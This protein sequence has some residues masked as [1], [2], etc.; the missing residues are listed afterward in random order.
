MERGVAFA[1]KQ[2]SAS[3]AGVNG[4][5]DVEDDPEAP[6]VHSLPVATHAG[7]LQDLRSQVAGRAAQGLHEG[8]L[9]DKLGE[10]KVC[11]FYQRLLVV[12]C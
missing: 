4:L 6:A 8:V 1:R 10:A 2:R 5:H 7:S 3:N 12:C 11:D 9:A